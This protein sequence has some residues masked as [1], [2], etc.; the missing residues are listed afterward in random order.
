MSLRL[1]LTLPLGRLLSMYKMSLGDPENLPEIMH[2]DV[3]VVRQENPDKAAPFALV[4]QIWNQIRD[5][6]PTLAS[7]LK[8]VST[9]YH[10]TQDMLSLVL[11]YVPMCSSF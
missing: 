4:R 3:E 7:F 2:Y 1:V 6:N 10:S 5:S 11:T 9:R 8:A